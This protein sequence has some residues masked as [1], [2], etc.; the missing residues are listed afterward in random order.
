MRLASPEGFVRT[1]WDRLSGIPGGRWTFSRVISLVV[2]YSGT[3]RPRVVELRAGHCRILMAGRRR[4]R[5]HLGSVHAIALANLAE[6]VS[7]LAVTYGLPAEARGIP[8]GLEV[9]YV[10]KGRGRMTGLCDTAIPDWRVEGEHTFPA[11]I[12]DE[13]GEVVAR[14]RVR[15]RIGPREAR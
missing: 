7:G 2:P 10:K 4:V 13:A 14:A 5:N 3:I 1:S 9:D 6:L 8:V 11:E 15:W 12:R